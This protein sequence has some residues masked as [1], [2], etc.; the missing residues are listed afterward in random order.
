MKEDVG[1]R[2]SEYSTVSILQG[3]YN[4]CVPPKNFDAWVKFDTV[5]AQRD[6]TRPSHSTSEYYDYLIKCTKS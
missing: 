2:I 1:I 3:L 5:D 6:I 4:Q